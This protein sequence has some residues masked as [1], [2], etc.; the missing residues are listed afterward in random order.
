MLEYEVHGAADA[1][2]IGVH[3]DVGD[4]AIQGFARGQQF[5][6]AR[7]RII[8]PQQRPVLGFAGTRQDPVDRGLEVDDRAMAIEIVPV[9]GVEHRP[10]AGRKHDAVPSR[11]FPDDSPFAA[12]EAGLALDIEDP[13]DIGPAA[14]LDD[15][16]AVDEFQTE[17][18]REVTPDRRLADTHRTDQE[19][20]GPGLFHRP[21]LGR[22]QARAQLRPDRNSDFPDMKKTG[23][24][25]GLPCSDR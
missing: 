21:M 10:A 12:P 3:G 1:A 15:M 11:Q 25:P 17:C 9:V 24:A 13:R 4:L 2:A 7:A 16:V 14:L 19:D 22:E 20:I 18:A 23:Q 6:H 5:L 8:G